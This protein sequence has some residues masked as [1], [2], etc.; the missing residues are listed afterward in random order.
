VATLRIVLDVIPVKEDG[1]TR[2][3]VCRSRVLGEWERHFK[4]DRSI[5]SLGRMKANDLEEIAWIAAR[6]E[7]DY[8]DNLHQFRTA[9]EVDL[10]TEQ[11]EAREKAREVAR[12]DALDRG[13][14]W[15]EAEARKFDRDF[16]REW[17]E[18]LAEAESG[19]TRRGR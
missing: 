7:W 16:D 14:E 5:S 15:T 2:R 18:D 6:M 13:D 1:N 12:Q 17:D 8:P 11:D 10:V 4:G 19:P 3:L 9:H